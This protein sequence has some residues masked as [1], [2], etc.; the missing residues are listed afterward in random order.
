MDDIDLVFGEFV[1]FVLRCSEERLRGSGTM[2][3][4]I[5]RFIKM[6]AGAVLPP[7]AER[8][9]VRAVPP[10]VEDRIPPA[11]QRSKSLR[12]DW[13]DDGRSDDGTADAALGPSGPEAEQPGQRCVVQQ[14]GLTAVDEN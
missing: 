3:T 8:A 12:L 1:E 13:V 10:A 11:A 2:V 5:E 7:E 9:P 14:T 4:R 6:I